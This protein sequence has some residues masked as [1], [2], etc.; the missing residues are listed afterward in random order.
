MNPPN[1][2]MMHGGGPVAVRELP[3]LVLE[4]LRVDEALRDQPD[5]A[6]EERRAEHLPHDRLDVVAVAVRDLHR[7]PHADERERRGADEHPPREPGADV[8]HPP[9]LHRADRLER[10]AVRD[11]GSDRRRRRHPEEEHEERRHQRPAAHPGHPDEE[12]R[13]ETEDRVFPV[14]A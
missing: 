1:A 7:R 3:L 10:G 5:R 12:P 6:E 13:Q 11:V 2:P 14:I 8:S 9:V 4:R